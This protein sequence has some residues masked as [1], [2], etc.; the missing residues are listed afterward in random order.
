VCAPAVVACAAP[1]GEKAASKGPVSGG[2]DLRVGDV[3]QSAKD[4]PRRR[5]ARSAAAGPNPSALSAHAVFDAA[6]ATVATAAAVAGTAPPDT[7]ELSFDGGGWSC[8]LQAFA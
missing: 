6:A 7:S 3:D 8:E 4:R 5:R 2:G 1:E